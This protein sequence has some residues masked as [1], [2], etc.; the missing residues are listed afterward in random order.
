MRL[1]GEKRSGSKFG[2]CDYYYYKGDIVEMKRISTE[3]K[4]KEHLKIQGGVWEIYIR[5][6]NELGK[7]RK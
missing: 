6:K 2:V 7:N 3:N 1:R 5:G 4:A